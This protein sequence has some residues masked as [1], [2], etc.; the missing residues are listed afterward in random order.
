MSKLSFTFYNYIQNNHGDNIDKLR[1]IF[2]ERLE[3]IPDRGVSSKVLMI[4]LG[5]ETR[6][7]YDIFRNVYM[8]YFRKIV[9]NQV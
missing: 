4:L 1:E 8:D 3:K 6:E 2:G 9:L 5:V 7:E